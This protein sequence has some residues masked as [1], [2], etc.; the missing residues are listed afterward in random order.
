MP[1]QQIK[2]ITVRSKQMGPAV[3]SSALALS[4]QMQTF[5]LACWAYTST[6]MSRIRQKEEILAKVPYVPGFFAQ[7]QYS[8]QEKCC[9]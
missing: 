1:D 4:C 7:D 3:V 2:M 9:P 6:E 8:C 5:R